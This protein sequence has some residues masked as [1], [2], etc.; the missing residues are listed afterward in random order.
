MNSMRSMTAFRAGDVL[1]VDR[2]LYKHYGVYCGDDK[3]VHFAADGENELDASKAFVQETTLAEFSKD[4][5]VTAEVRNKPSLSPKQTVQR[6]LS[7]VGKQKGEYNL[8]FNNCEHFANWCKY[9]EHHS[10]QVVNVAVAGLALA[11]AG[12][13]IGRVLKEGFDV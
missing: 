11:A 8:V 7:Q 6:A 9:G 4:G 3:I 13:V 5:I 1:V 12:F 10:R 2:L